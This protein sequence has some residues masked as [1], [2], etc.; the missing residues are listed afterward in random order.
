MPRQTSMQT[1]EKK[2]S[3]MKSELSVAKTKYEKVAQELLRLQKQ[4]EQMEALSIYEAFKKSGKSYRELMVF[5][6][7]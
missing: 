2:I 6:G 4:K 7:K 5:L 1:I 3:K